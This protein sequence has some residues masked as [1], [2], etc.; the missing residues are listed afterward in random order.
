MRLSDLAEF[1]ALVARYP[2]EILPARF[3]KII[4]RHGL[5]T[6]V[7]NYAL[8]ARLLMR[9]VIKISSINPT[10]W[11]RDRLLQA[12]PPAVKDVGLLAARR[13]IFW[14]VISFI[15]DQCQ[16]P[17]WTWRNV[18]YGDDRTSTLARLGCIGRQIVTRLFRA[19]HAFLGSVRRK[20]SRAPNTA[21][22]K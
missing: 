14:R 9:S 3:W 16:M 8:M 22:G 17:A 5:S 1:A 20:Y 10:N 15:Y 18:C 19:S 7:G 11:H 21:E 4:R 12:S 13:H 2:K 6:A